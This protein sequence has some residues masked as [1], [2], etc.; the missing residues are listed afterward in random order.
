MCYIKN[1]GL[2]AVGQVYCSKRHNSSEPAHSELFNMEFNHYLHNSIVLYKFGWISMGSVCNR[3][4]KSTRK[5]LTLEEAKNKKLKKREDSRNR[6]HS[7]DE[8]IV[9]IL[10]Q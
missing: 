7:L 3:G 9:P 1:V 10:A 8:K 2:H 5:V 4:R 6:H